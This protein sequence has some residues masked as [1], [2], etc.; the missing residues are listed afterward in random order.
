MIAVFHGAIRRIEAFPVPTLAAINATALGGGLEVALACDLIVA[1]AGAKLGQPEIKL[2]VFPPVAAVLLP[3]RLPP[4]RANELLFGGCTISAEEALDLGLVN[5]VLPRE[6]F[7]ADA[8]AFAATFLEHSRAALL[9]T[10]KAMRA[11]AG[12]GFEEA[13]S[14]A[15]AVYLDELMRSAD[16]KEGLEAFV[17]KRKPVWKH[18]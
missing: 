3:R 13:L 12:R 2:A 9:S 16:A 1:A 5:R 8:R 17:A 7:A 6:S 10:K 18:R 14:A 11:A 4:V 15:E